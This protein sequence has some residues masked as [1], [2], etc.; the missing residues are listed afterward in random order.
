MLCSVFYYYVLYSLTQILEQIFC[1]LS[2]WDVD[3][4]RLK[5][6]GGSA[7]ACGSSWVQKHIFNSSRL[8]L[9]N[10]HQRSVDDIRAGRSASNFHGRCRWN[11]NQKEDVSDR[12]AVFLRKRLFWIFIPL[13]LQCHFELHVMV[14]K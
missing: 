13:T 11:P 1:S 6:S 8:T 12:S 10:H 2:L 7:G 14:F 3:S 9:V 4:T 5:R